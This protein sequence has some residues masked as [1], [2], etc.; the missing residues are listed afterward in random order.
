MYAVAKRIRAVILDFDGTLVDSNRLKRL[1][2]FSCGEKFNI[3]SGLI[4]EILTN[5][6]KFTRSQVFELIRSKQTK[7]DATQE[8]LLDHYD[9]QTFSE[10]V[11]L[12]L[13]AGAA[14]FLGAL[15][16]KGIRAFISSATPEETLHKI[17][18][19]RGDLGTIRRAFGAPESKEDHVKHI[20]A[21]LQLIPNEILYVGD[22]N[23]DYE[24]AKL[25]GCEFVGV[26]EA[27]ERITSKQFPYAPT[28]RAFSL[29]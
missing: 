22:S 26:F 24:C 9:R 13:R 29:V 7:N 8:A 18:K 27:N 17:I 6:P 14:E 4:E 1:A 12:P 19:T 15:H 25:S 16:E 3:E 10:I 23:A 11:K 20:A 2:F 21:E 5:N 28:F